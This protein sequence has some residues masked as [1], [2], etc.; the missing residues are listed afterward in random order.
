LVW[1]NK[2]SKKKIK[3]IKKKLYTLWGCDNLTLRDKK[4]E[5]E[6]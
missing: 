1:D 4:K 6:K 3:N 2:K 5:F